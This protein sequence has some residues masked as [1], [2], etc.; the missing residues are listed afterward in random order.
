MYFSHTLQENFQPARE[1]HDHE[2]KSFRTHTLLKE[3][4]IATPLHA[5]I[6]DEKL[7]ACQVKKL[8]RRLDE[9]VPSPG[10]GHGH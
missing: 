2:G 3:P 4:P 6:I 9:S 10:V 1:K 5:P 8:S 7:V